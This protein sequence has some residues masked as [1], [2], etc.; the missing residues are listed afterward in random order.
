MYIVPYDSL[1]R[2]DITS[3]L[4]LLQ[5]LLNSLNALSPA[6]PEEALA[7]PSGS[8]SSSLLHTPLPPPAEGI[9][10]RNTALAL[11]TKTKAIDTAS[12]LLLN[13]SKRLD[14]T[15]NKS[16]SEWTDLLRL[17]RSGQW[18]IEARPAQVPPRTGT[19]STPFVPNIP[20]DKMARDLCIFC[21]IEESAYRW[22]QAGLVRLD[23]GTATSGGKE[24]EKL[25]IPERLEGRRRMVVRLNIDG[26][27]PEDSVYRPAVDTPHGEDIHSTLIQV[28]QELFE[29]E[30]FAEVY[31]DNALYNTQV[32]ELW[33]TSITCS[34]FAKREISHLASPQRA[35]QSK[36]V[37]QTHLRSHSRC[38]ISKI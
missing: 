8:I 25:N 2:S 4:D 7:L 12:D 16:Q 9:H 19:S 23:S 14:S 10:V 29:E 28:Q 33:L 37:I 15:T 5:L 13:A 21:G 27:F 3:A 35:M 11:A 38:R 36:S 6:V 24:R 30:I 20:I 32:R 18:R 17:K 34:S 31:F 26:L 1:A 22:R